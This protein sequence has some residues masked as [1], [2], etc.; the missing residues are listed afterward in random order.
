MKMQFVVVAIVGALA[1]QGCA[2]NTKGQEPD[3]RRGFGCRPRGRPGQAGDGGS[4]CGGRCRAGWCLRLSRGPAGQGD[5]AGRRFGQ[6]RH[7]GS[8]LFDTNSARISPSFQ[9]TLTRSPARSPSIPRPPSMWSDIPTALARQTTTRSLL[10][11]ASSVTAYRV[12]YGVAPTRPPPPA[13]AKRSPT[14]PP[15]R[16]RAEPSGRDVR[17]PIRDRAADGEP[18]V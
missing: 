6:A 12:P 10:E 2:T 5:R 4:W 16:A 1:I 13:R 9:Q 3:H 7:P 18:A 15:P 8:A 11:R 14:M 17:A